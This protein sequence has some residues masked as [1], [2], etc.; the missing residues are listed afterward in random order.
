MTAKS[1]AK[2]APVKS[3]GAEAKQDKATVEY[4]TLLFKALERA[5]AL[6]WE[7]RFDSGLV[8]VAH[9]GEEW[10]LDVKNFR[11]LGAPGRDYVLLE[12]ALIEEEARLVRKA[13]DE[14]LL[15]STLAKLTPEECRVL[16]H[17]RR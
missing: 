13:A 17:P 2:K 15:R 5:Y 3:Q 10:E 14:Q 11:E 16:G 4:Y 8:I 9:G 7:I 12:M 6:S 1:S